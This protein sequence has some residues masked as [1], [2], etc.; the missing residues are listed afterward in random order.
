[1]VRTKL[2]PHINGFVDRYGRKI[3]AWCRHWGLQESDAQDVTQTV[4]LDLAR[5]MANFVYRPTGSFRS[6]LKTIAHRTWC[7]YLDARRRTISGTSDDS[8]KPRSY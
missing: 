8:K 4:L 7:D 2:P 1:M 6:W 5:Q 3:Y